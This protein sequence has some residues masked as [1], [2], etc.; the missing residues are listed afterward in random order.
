MTTNV[1]TFLREF[2][3]F[4]ATARR[5]GTVRIRDGAGEFFFTAVGSR[6]TLL[7]SAKG[8]IVFPHDLTK[9]TLSAEAWK[10]SL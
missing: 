10:A 4:K 3:R 9:P 5:G 2:T 7:G 6:K 8:K 1:R